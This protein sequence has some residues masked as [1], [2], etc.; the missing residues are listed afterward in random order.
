MISAS[1]GD[2]SI[3]IT[4]AKGCPQGGVLSPLLWLLV[5]DSLLRKLTQLGYEVIGYADD[6]VLTIRGKYDGT[7]S[8][9]LQSALNCTLSWCEQQGLTINPNKTVII[10]FTNRRKHDLRPPTLK[11][12]QLTFSK[13]VKYL[14]VILYQKL[15]WNAHLDYAIKKAT[16]AIWACNRMFGKTWGLK[17]RLALWSYV[18]IARPRVTYASIVWWPKTQQV[19][20]QAKLNKLQR[21]ACLSVTSAMKTTPTAAMEAMLY[22]L[23]LHLH[24]RQ[25]A[26]LGALRLKRCNNLLEGDPMGH[27]RILKDFN[28]SSLATTVSDCMEVRPNMDMP[29]EVIDTNRHMWS[30]GGP[31]LPQGTIC[32]YTDGSKMG[33][34]TGSGVFGPR[35]RETIPMGL[36]PTVFQAEVYAIYICAKTCLIRNYRH[37][38][39]GIFSD[40][41]AALLALKSSKCDSK[42]V[43]ECIASLRELATRHNRIMLFWVPGHCGIEGNEMA[44]EL[45]RQGSSNSFVGP[46]PFL[47]ISKS[48]TRQGILDWG[49]EQI[50]SIWSKMRGLRQAKAF[51]TPS[52]SITKKLLGLNRRELRTIAGLLTGHCPARYHL[53][54]IGIW[55]NNLCRF[56]LLELESSAHLFCFC[57]ALVSQRVRFLGSHLL[58]PYDVWHTRPRKVIQFIDCIAPNWDKPCLQNNPSSSTSMEVS[59]L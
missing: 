31:E 21:L 1:L 20:C 47:G 53:H 41:Q 57:G 40:S 30:H 17:P 15:N 38:K 8:D 29:Y 35:I 49:R 28:I 50:A 52:P 16:T 43:W 7:L 59:N 25:E 48:A 22:I 42:L 24:V 37:A 54:K 18:T 26:V 44:D 55:P 34:R 45:A 9:R 14:G 46:E 27:S 5:V 12:T 10:P 56:C 19:T 23:P 33:C 6:V 4:A 3:T 2:T 58:S 13:E 11:G 39:I 51:I 36:W 32:F